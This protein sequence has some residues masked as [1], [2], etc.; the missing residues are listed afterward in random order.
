LPL[1]YV[2]CVQKVAFDQFKVYQRELFVL[3]LGVEANKSSHAD[4]YPLI[5]VA[6][7]ARLFLI[8]S[9]IYRCFVMYCKIIA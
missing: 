8:S 6:N 2:E 9:L 7:M 4:I 3:I 1:A 5:W